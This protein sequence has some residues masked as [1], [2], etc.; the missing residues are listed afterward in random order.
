MS[1]GNEGKDVIKV[2]KDT[3]YGIIIV[4]LAGLLVLS[5]LTQ[6]FGIVKPAAAAAPAAPTGTDQ[7][8]A[9][10]QAAPAQPTGGT[11]PA[12]GL[13]QLAVDDGVLP[14]LGQSTAPVT[15]VEFSDFQCP[16]CGRLYS[17]AEAQIRT[18]YISS[19][20][21][22]FY[23]RDFP[24][25]SIHPDAMAGAIAG[26]CANDQ[27]K[28]WE[29]HDKLFDNQATWSSMADPKSTL[30]QYAKDLGLDTAAFDSCYENQ[31]HVSEINSD[32]NT[33]VQYGVQGTPGVYIKI[34]KGK[35]D[36]ASIQ[37]VATS[38]QLTVYDGGTDY[39]VFVPG[40]YPYSTFDA[41]LSKVSY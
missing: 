15:I 33:G 1:D 18:N 41:V 31:S 5:I 22:K 40:A 38:N 29:M 14:A 8:T 12:A 28:F 39:I 26:R 3:L 9:G 20:K 17:D 13:A 25:T 21:V 30:E 2:S 34:P 19:G 6:G 24:L 4:G 11:A 16:Y 36:L 10:T 7:G 32:E 27:G 35:V 37:S 23:Y